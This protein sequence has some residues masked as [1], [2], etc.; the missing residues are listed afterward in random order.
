MMRYV[1]S[2]VGAG[3]L[4]GV[5]G[6]EAVPDAGVFQLIYVVVTAMAVVAVIASLAI[7][8]H[9]SEGAVG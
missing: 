7:H 1:G 4:A 6:G 3:I 9:I 5:L 2:I 8:G